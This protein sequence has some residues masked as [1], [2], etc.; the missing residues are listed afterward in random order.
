[1][2]NCFGYLG[3]SLDAFPLVGPIYGRL[4]STGMD[5]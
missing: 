4:E 1:M 5:R 3:S 2:G